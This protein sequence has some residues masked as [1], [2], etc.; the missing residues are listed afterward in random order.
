[1]RERVDVRARML[2]RDDDPRR[3]GPRLSPTSCVMTVKEIVEAGLMRR[4]RGRARVAK[5]LEVED[6]RLRDRIEKPVHL[7]GPPRNHDEA[8]DFVGISLCIGRRSG[9]A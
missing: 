3:S 2:G 4:V 5:L 9:P 7:S 8:S 1:M 6:A